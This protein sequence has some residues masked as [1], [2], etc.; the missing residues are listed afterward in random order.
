MSSDLKRV[1]DYAA[2]VR[3]GELPSCRLIRKTVERWYNDWQ[4]KDLYFDAKPYLLFCSFCRELQHY[5]GEFAGQ[6]F[7]PETWQ[8][9]FAANVLGWHRKSTG[10]RRYTAADL[11]VPRKNGKTMFAAAFAAF[12][13]LLDGEAGAEVY[14]AAVDKAQAKICFDAAK[15]MLEKSIFAK[16]IRPLRSVVEYPNGDSVLAPLSKETKNKDG[17]NPHAAI[18]DERHAWASNEMNDVIKT[19]MGARSQ[20]MIISITTAGLDTSF[21]YYQDLMVY[22]DVLEGLK[23][24]DDHF[25]MLY[26]PD[27]DADWNDREVWKQVNPNLGI[28][29]SWE[30]M[31]NMYAE[32]KLK[33]GSTLV[34]FL[35]KNLNMWVDAPEVWIP[36]DDI[37]ANN[38]ASVVIPP[39]EECYVGID[40]ARK[41]DVAAVSFFFPRLKALRYL[42]VIPEAKVEENKDIV[43]YRRWSEE[44]WMK[45]L[46][47]RVIDEDMFI[48]LILIECERWNIRKICY[49]PWGMWNLL[50]K[51]GKYEECLMEFQQS[52]RFMSVPTKWLES[53]VI[54]HELN[55]LGNPVIRWMFKNVVIYHDP[56]DNIKLDKAKA[57]NK[58]DGVVATVDAI[59]GWLNETAGETGEI[60]KS[61]S[62]RSI[63]LDQ[64]LDEEDEDEEDDF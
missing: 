46:P 37:L 13:L 60:Y 31:E 52:I 38:D 40:F 8:L 33:G 45:V 14:T 10:K 22:V 3:S 15:K 12:F 58:I 2:Q 47:G 64:L 44:G 49:D 61:H 1:H 32:A 63:N 56:N 41:T 18:C 19:G 57:R 43:D 35:V 24:M 51:F 20:P 28:S 62:L 26:M 5:K 39:K 59:G 42:F 54:T 50:G 9:F 34:S 17:L 48:A 4:R 16:L 55:F 11:L 36:D 6:S 7:E 30:Y 25:L 21:P 23:E 29:L 27:K 53:H